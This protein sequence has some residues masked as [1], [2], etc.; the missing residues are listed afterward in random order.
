MNRFF[1]TIPHYVKEI[2]PEI[3]NRINPAA[4]LR[5]IAEPGVNL[6][7]DWPR[8]KR[9]L[10][11]AHQ[12]FPN[13]N[14]QRNNINLNIGQEY[15]EKLSLF[16]SKDF[17]GE[18]IYLPEKEL[19]PPEKELLLL[20]YYDPF[21]EEID[22]FIASGKFDFFLDVHSMND[23]NSSYE[24]QDSRPEI[25]LGNRGNEEGERRLDRP[26]ITF[27]PEKL[28]A[29]R[30]ALRTK[31]YDCRLNTPF[32]GGYIIQKYAKSFPCILVEIN[33]KVFME[34]DDGEVIS[35]KVEE[36][37]KDLWEVFNDTS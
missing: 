15:E 31:G 34:T 25:C 24:N 26:G 37:N 4:N 17:H 1:L 14:R 7:F 18:K 10:A 3:K 22:K 16:P 5:E 20:Q 11:K 28:R 19:I 29:I 12:C 35:E 36:L 8:I 2:L 13:L 21:Y 9:V 23:Q 27:P 6:I 33:K 32:S 30:Q